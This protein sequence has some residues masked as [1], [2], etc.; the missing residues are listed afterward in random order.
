M[1]Y[2]NETEGFDVGYGEVTK[3]R[4]VVNHIPRKHGS[5]CGRRSNIAIRDEVSLCS[6]LIHTQWR[7]LG[8]AA[9][10]CAKDRRIELDFP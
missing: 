3:H 5:V 9:M 2:V 4:G 10:S 8:N 7:S 1:N 6:L